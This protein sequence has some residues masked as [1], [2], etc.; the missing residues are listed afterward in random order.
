MLKQN[1]IDEICFFRIEISDKH[2]IV[3][4]QLQ[5]EAD[6]LFSDVSSLGGWDGLQFH[7]DQVNS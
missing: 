2:N 7:L 1:D 5:L 6:L 4:Q 3:G